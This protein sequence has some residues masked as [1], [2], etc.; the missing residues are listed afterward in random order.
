M[1]LPF[2]L[3]YEFHLDSTNNIMMIILNAR[4]VVM[5]VSDSS[6]YIQVGFVQGVEW[7]TKLTLSKV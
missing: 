7:W 6:G 5:S 2:F 4:G 3:Q 1:T